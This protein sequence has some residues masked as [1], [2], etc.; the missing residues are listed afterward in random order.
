MDMY[1][2]KF[3]CTGW[4]MS[5]TRYF[6]ASSTLEAIHDIDYAMQHGM[7]TSKQIKIYSVKLYNRFTNKWESQDLDCLRT[8][9]RQDSRG[10]YIIHQNSPS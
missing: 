1:K 10:R 2:I 7:I 9:Y 6:T 3:K 4:V 5:S 8:K